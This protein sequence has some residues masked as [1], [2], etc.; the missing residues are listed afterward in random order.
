MIT[1]MWRPVKYRGFYNQKLS[2]IISDAILDSDFEV[3]NYLITLGRVGNLVSLDSFCLSNLDMIADNAKNYNVRDWLFQKY[4]TFNRQNYEFNFIHFSHCYNTETSFMGSYFH[5]FKEFDGNK[6]NYFKIIHEQGD[7]LDYTNVYDARIENPD[8]IYWQ[9]CD[10]E[11]WDN[12]KLADPNI[13]QFD[14][15]IVAIINLNSILPKVL[16]NICG[17][18]LTNFVYDTTD[19]YYEINYKP[20]LIKS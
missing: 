9:H 11:I 15:Y 8:I 14:E 5:I 2:E 13:T 19:N 10:V 7:E 17:E 18:Y 12:T 20:S 16:V 1:Q 6:V 4:K 3:L